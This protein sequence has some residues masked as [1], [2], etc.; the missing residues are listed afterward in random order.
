MT[1]AR[2]DDLI[3]P[4]PRLMV[5][6]ALADVDEIRFDLLAKALE[7]SAPTLSK[8]LSRL[9]EAGYVATAPDPSDSRRQW[10]FLTELGRTA[11]DGHL[12]A[13]R[14]LMA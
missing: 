1:T 9:S 6:A 7:M 10:V 2:F 11:F 12:A 8:H 3:H 4:R 13:L 14:D 5:C